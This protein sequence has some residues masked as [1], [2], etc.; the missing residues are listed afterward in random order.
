MVRC[1]KKIMSEILD[2]ISQ[3]QP[4]P[5]PATWNSCKLHYH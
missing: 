2:T 4:N 3:E 1:A 5:F